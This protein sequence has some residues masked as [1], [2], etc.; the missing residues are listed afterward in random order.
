MNDL[1]PA[2]VPA[3]DGSVLIPLVDPKRPG[4]PSEAFLAYGSALLRRSA[5]RPPAPRPKRASGV[6]YASYLCPGCRVCRLFQAD[7]LCQFCSDTG[8]PKALARR[9][10]PAAPTTAATVA[11]PSVPAA[12][13]PGAAPYGDDDPLTD[14][15][16]I[17]YEPR[18]ARE[19]LIALGGRRYER[20][21]G[22][23]GLGPQ[24]A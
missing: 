2:P 21:R 16:E 3:P 9:P 17:E 1:S 8:H 11:S 10:A 20:G 4:R 23:F 19:S 15:E 18:L 5:A 12:D 6:G 14:H 7:T 24:R 22:R 13:A